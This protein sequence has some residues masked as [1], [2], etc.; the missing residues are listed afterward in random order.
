MNI[1]GYLKSDVI[2]VSI[3]SINN[4]REMNLLQFISMIIQISST[5]Q[6]KIWVVRFSLKIKNIVT[7]LS[8]E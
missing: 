5:Y 3:A 2:Q 8:L 7:F 1:S 6:Y 4:M